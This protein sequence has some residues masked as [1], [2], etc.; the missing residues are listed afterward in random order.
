[1]A[2]TLLLD[3]VRGPDVQAAGL[4]GVVRLAAA[5]ALELPFSAGL[6]AGGMLLLVVLLPAKPLGVADHPPPPAALLADAAC[7]AR[8]MLVVAAKAAAAK[9]GALA[10]PAPACWLLR[11]MLPSLLASLPGDT[12]WL[13][14]CPMLGLLPLC[15][16]DTALLGCCAT[17]A[18]PLVPPLLLGPVL[19]LVLVLKAF[20]CLLLAMLLVVVL[21]LWPALPLGMAGSALRLCGCCCRCSNA[22]AR[23]RC[24][25]SRALVAF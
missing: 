11:A 3:A 5:A 2:Q 25:W 6:E 4:D 8:V 15:K 20:G 19:V 16:A 12:W 14:C 13:G 22:P 1:M 21:L 24:C 9:G 18:A 7:L 23:S 17:A 10:A